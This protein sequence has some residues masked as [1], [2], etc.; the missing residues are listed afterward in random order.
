MTN[1]VKT[2]VA[3]V[4]LMAA[5]L[6]ASASTFDFED[7]ASGDFVTDVTSSDGLVTASVS[8]IDRDP[9]RDP[10]FAVGAARAFD[11][12][13]TG[14]ADPDLEIDF[15]DDTTGL[16]DTSFRPGNVLI[17]QNPRSG[18]TLDDSGT[19]GSLS[20]DFTSGP[21]GFTGFTIVDDATITV[22]AS[23]LGGG[24]FD[25]GTFDVAADR[26]FE[27][28]SFGEVSDV[29]GLTFDFGSASGA[30][31]DLTF[32][33][34]AAVP[35]PAALPLLLAGLGGLGLIARRRKAAS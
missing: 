32:A 14:T 35:V 22:T 24:L 9:R 2:T 19:G 13:A 20:F 15:I 12:E 5:P 34:I 27:T 10:V 26:G 28:F 33:D 23:L 3:A 16:V 18:D 30:I 11:T 17:V 4:A 7:F 8:A 21:V 6:V 31:D 29:I 1:F 25:V